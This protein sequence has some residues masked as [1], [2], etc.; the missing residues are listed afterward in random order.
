MDEVGKPL[1]AG[2]PS[3]PRPARRDTLHLRFIL[4]PDHQRGH[5]VSL[6]GFAR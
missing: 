2:P 4:L 1:G 3:V 5:A 6:V